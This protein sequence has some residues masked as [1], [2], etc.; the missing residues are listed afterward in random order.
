MESVDR[1]AFAIPLRP[2]AVSD[3]EELARAATADPS[4]VDLSRQLGMQRAMAWV[5]LSEAPILTVYMEWKVDPVDG[6][7][8]YEESQEQMARQIQTVLRQAA[9]SPEDAELDAAASRAEVI[10]DWACEDGSR[11]LDVRCYSQ[12]V[13]PEKAAAAREFLDD[14]K[15]PMMFRLYSR[16]RQ[17]VGMKCT[18][19]WAEPTASGDI[20]LIE[21]YESDD[22]DNS[23]DQLA[24]SAYDLDEM[25]LL[26]TTLTFGWAPGNMP[27]LRPIYDWGGDH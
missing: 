6:L 5:Q 24:R 20:L 26:R 15:D 10:F 18:T 16:L 13:S 1:V 27:E 4:L 17:R 8:G 11:G 23:F 7:Q 2:N 9:A 21:L 3:V 12:L 22:L 25:T 14:L 19:V